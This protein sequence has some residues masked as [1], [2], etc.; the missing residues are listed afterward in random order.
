MMWNLQQIQQLYVSL[1]NGHSSP[2]RWRLK[3]LSLLWYA[4]LHHEQLNATISLELNDN[5]A[6]ND[7][8]Q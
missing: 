6:C 1:P 4:S 8:Q 3:Q 2:I 5:L 7:C